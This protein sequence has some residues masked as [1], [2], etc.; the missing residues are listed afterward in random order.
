[1]V[2]SHP[3]ALMFSGAL[4]VHAA[5]AGASVQPAPVKRAQGIAKD[6]DHAVMKQFF[7]E[8]QAATEGQKIATPD[9]GYGFE[10]STW[11]APESWCIKALKLQKNKT[12]ER[13]LIRQLGGQRVAVVTTVSDCEPEHCETT[14]WVLSGRSGLRKSPI[15]LDHNLV[16]SPDQRVLYVGHTNPSPKGYEASLNRID[17]KTLA[18]TLVAP[19]AMP[20]LSPSGRWIVCRD[21][22]GNVHRFGTE[23]EP[24][25]QIHTL[26]LGKLRISTSPHIGVD[27]RPVVFVA[28]QGKER[29]VRLR[30]VTPCHQGDEVVEEIDWVEAPARPKGK[31]P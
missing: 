2:H 21:A 6:S 23:G 10:R 4:M 31:Q 5:T 9:Q 7:R 30:V 16:L 12:L 8:V 3:F 22:Q 13:C 1:M 15:P 27:L 25:E 14:Y 26:R 18:H 11:Y 29:P 28:R 20:V 24:M 17:L 19:C